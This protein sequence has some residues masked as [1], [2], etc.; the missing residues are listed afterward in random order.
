MPPGKICWL[1]SHAVPQRCKRPGFTRANQDMKLQT[2]NEQQTRPTGALGREDYMAAL[3]MRRSNDK[4]QSANKTD[5]CP[6][7]PKSGSYICADNSVQTR[8]VRGVLHNVDFAASRPALRAL[9]QQPV[10]GPCAGSILCGQSRAHFKATVGE[11]QAI[12]TRNPTRTEQKWSLAVGTNDIVAPCGD[13]QRRVLN[14]H[15]SREVELC[16]ERRL[17][18]VVLGDLPRRC[19]E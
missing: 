12:A 7:P 3:Q 2:L 18:S 11:R 15:V 10:R 13:Y 5:R 1:T 19:V 6:C 14:A 16:F 9:W 4:H 8:N 17:V